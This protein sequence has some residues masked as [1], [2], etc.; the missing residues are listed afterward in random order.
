MA[1]PHTFD[2]ELFQIV[3]VPIVHDLCGD[4]TLTAKF[5]GV[6]IGSTDS[7]TSYEQ[8]RSSSYTVFTMD[9]AY[10]NLTIPYTLSAELTMYPKSQHT[11][12][13]SKESSSVIYF[14]SPCLDLFELTATTQREIEEDKYTGVKKPWLLTEFTIEPELCVP[15][16][17]YDITSVIGPDGQDYK[18][19]MI[20]YFDGVLDGGFNEGFFEVRAFMSQY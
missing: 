20:S 11:T 17:T 12:A 2:H 8:V 13:D 15:T 19:Y 10:F 16:V 18:S 3:T 14:K 9:T 4:L 5:N 7:P 1:D 6:V